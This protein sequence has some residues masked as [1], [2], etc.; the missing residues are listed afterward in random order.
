MPHSN[1]MMAND[2]ND[3][4]NEAQEQVK[5]HTAQNRQAKN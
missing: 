5:E 1:M 3:D 2:G 4:D